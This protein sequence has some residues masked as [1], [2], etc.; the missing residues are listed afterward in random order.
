MP[1][2]DGRDTLSREVVVRHTVRVVV[3]NA[4]LVFDVLKAP[5]R[6]RSGRETVKRP[7]IDV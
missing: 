4:Q 1:W 5:G 2:F 6:A 3:I 7:A